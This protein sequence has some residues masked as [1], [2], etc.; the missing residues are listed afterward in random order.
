MQCKLFLTVFV[1]LALEAQTHSPPRRAQFLGVGE[2][3]NLR[4]KNEEVGESAGS[5]SEEERVN[6]LNLLFVF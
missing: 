6:P 3:E 5:E 1:S 4:A 2:R